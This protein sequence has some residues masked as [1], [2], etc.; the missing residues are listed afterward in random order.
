MAPTVS[1]VIPCY[2]QSRYL[3][4][5]VNSV[6]SQSF[7]DWECIIVSDASPDDVKDVALQL[8]AGDTRISFIESV[9]NLGLAGARNLGIANAKGQYIL[10]LDAD[11][12]I[13]SSYLE[14]AVAEFRKNTELKL[15]Y[16]KAELFGE[17]TGE[18][19]L[20]PYHYGL[21][22]GRNPIYCS[23]IYKKRDWEACGGYDASIK[24]GLED[25]DFWL[26]LLDENSQVLQLQGIGFYYR[27]HG[28]TMIHHLT[29][30]VAQYHNSKSELL[31][32]HRDK[33]LSWSTN[34]L[35][36]LLEQLQYQRNVEH[37]I[38]QNP[39]SRW[40]YRLARLIARGL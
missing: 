2:N 9:R 3:P 22:F 23:A 37:K 17:E 1:I 19:Q 32:R 39:A 14:N 20:P 38:A 16:A 8:C 12:K 13:A 5:A 4:D 10:P 6:V 7:Q 21:L 24:V 18:W 35:T 25:W 34:C 31:L 29:E 33:W 11:D 36:P 15:V 40:L 26:K 30:D 28:Q 27:K